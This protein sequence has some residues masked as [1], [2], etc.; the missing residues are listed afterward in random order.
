MAGLLICE[1]QL[2][3][4]A[5]RVMIICPAN[6]RRLVVRSDRPSSTG[7][8]DDIAELIEAAGKRKLEPEEMKRL[9]ISA[10]R[11]FSKM[12]SRQGSRA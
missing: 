2:R 5:E 4:L 6:L 10:P 11:N 12:I 1:L 7:K 3:G 8:S 9:Q